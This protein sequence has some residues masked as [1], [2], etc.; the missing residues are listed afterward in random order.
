MDQRLTVTPFRIKE[1]K[2]RADDKEVH[3]RDR[4][5]GT[6]VAIDIAGRTIDIKTSKDSEGFHPS[7]I[8]S[9][10]LTEI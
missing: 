5:I 9:K 8:L 4:R 7:S 10:S 6:C 3:H 2:I 1:T